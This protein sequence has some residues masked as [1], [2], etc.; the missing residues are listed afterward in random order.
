MVRIRRLRILLLA[1]LLCTA[2]TAHFDENKGGGK[3]G[4]GKKGGKGKGGQAARLRVVVTA[5]NK[6]VAGAEVYVNSGSYVK[7]EVTN[8]N[9][10]AVFPGVPHGSAAIQVTASGYVTFAT[11]VDLT[12]E[13]QQLQVEL[14]K[15]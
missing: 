1:A 6:P 12:Q 2:V 3:K 13:G 14:T 5:Q 7:K 4:E 15:R 11:K 9:G 8:P 10:A